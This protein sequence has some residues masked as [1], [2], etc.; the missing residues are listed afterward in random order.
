VAVPLHISTVCIKKAGNVRRVWAG[1]MFIIRILSTFSQNQ[2]T[3][4]EKVAHEI[5]K[6]YLYFLATKRLLWLVQFVRCKTKVCR[7]QAFNT[8]N[9]S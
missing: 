6:K 9:N 2:K 8:E 7:N 3:Y 4:S 1:K 5:Y